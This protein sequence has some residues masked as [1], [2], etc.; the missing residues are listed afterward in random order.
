MEFRIKALDHTRGIVACVVDAV[1]E[2]DARRQLALK[3]FRVISLSPVRHLRFLARAPQ[4]QLAVF[5]QQ[6]V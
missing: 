4:L 5:S 3:E 1:D 6:L 2:A